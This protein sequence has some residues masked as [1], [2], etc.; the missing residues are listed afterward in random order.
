MKRFLIV[1]SS[2]LLFC[3]L[4]SS[5][6]GF[7]SKVQVKA[8]PDLYVPLGSKSVELKQFLTAQ[9]MAELLGDSETGLKIYEYTGDSKDNA[10]SYLLYFPLME[11]NF[12]FSEYMNGLDLT[13]L[14]HSIPRIDFT[15]P[16]LDNLEVEPQTV[17]IPTSNDYTGKTLDGTSA[18]VVNSLLTSIIHMELEE[19]EIPVTGQGLKS[20]TFES[21]N[22]VT[23]TMESTVEGSSLVFIPD[24]VLTFADGSQIPFV[25]AGDGKYVADFSGK[26]IDVGNITLSGTVG[27]SGE[28]FEGNTV[29]E[30]GI[31]AR[32]VVQTALDKGFTSITA[33]IPEGT[34]LSK[35]ISYEL[36]EEMQKMVSKISFAQTG[37][38]LDVNNTLP[39]GNDIGINMKI[40]A[41]NNL[42]ASQTAV[43]GESHLEFLSGAFDFIPAMNPNLQMTMAVTLPNYDEVTNTVTFENVIPGQSYGLEGVL[44]VVTEWD[45]L[46]VKTENSFEGFFPEEGMMDISQVMGFIPEG[47]SFKEI[48]AKIYLNSSIQNLNLSGKVKINETYLLGDELNPEIISMK[49]KLVLPSEDCYEWQTALPEASADFTSG[50]TSFINSKPDTMSLSYSLNVDEIEI[51][52]QDLETG[53]NISADFILKLPLELNIQGNESPDYASNG[54]KYVKFDI[55]EMAGIYSDEPGAN[56]DLLGR[57]EAPSG[58][59]TDNQFEE[60][61]SKIEKLSLEV[62]YDNQLGFSALAE[63]KD[64]ATGIQRFF[65]LEKGKGFSEITLQGSEILTVKDVYPFSPKVYI[66]LPNTTEGKSFMLKKDANI[67]IKIAVSEES[68]L[69][70]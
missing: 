24:V 1:L 15:V 66:Y 29:S 2:L 54:S 67:K 42:D 4:L 64:D 7:F 32:I 18:L 63:F 28:V 6:E 33:E 59:E 20:L 60:I 3:F 5:C 38:K 70:T 10:M 43:T 53:A 25:D 34:E 56:N 11:M 51:F 22:K 8:K 35:T 16:S 55:F 65:N 26:K 21:G 30:E 58:E 9:K 31:G 47:I 27:I 37:V 62:E 41:F 19:R 36:P 52:S 12:D 68:L 49:D 45:S 23:F 48:G 14:S 44:S 40:P 57:E 17:V 46:V 50:I 69:G 61:L 13:D 39:A